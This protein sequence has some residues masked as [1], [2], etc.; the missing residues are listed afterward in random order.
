MSPTSGSLQTDRSIDQQISQIFCPWTSSN[1]IV[2]FFLCEISCTFGDCSVISFHPS[3]YNGII[4]LVLTDLLIINPDFQIQLVS[5][6]GTLDTFNS[7]W[8][9]L[10]FF[11]W[12]SFL[13]A[14]CLSIQL[15]KSQGWNTWL[16]I[17][18]LPM[19]FSCLLNKMYLLEHDMQN[20]PQCVLQPHFPAASPTP[21]PLTICPTH[22]T[23]SH[24][25]NWR[26]VLLSLSLL[27]PQSE[28]IFLRDDSLIKI[29]LDYQGS[30]FSYTIC[31]LVSQDLWSYSLWSRMI[32]MKSY[33][34][35]YF[36]C[37]LKQL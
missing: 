21:P 13:K 11:F 34:T 37:V 6:G 29:I 12:Q 8:P 27:V 18:N 19:P 9:P 5:S 31:N 24:K 28:V 20:P 25:M 32:C 22:K 36:Y 23:N 2:L 35:S 15:R 14:K 17:Q 26:L 4:S 33:H 16:V 3:P 7:A 30:S 1:L 10:F